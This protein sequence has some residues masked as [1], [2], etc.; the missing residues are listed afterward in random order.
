MTSY[1]EICWLFRINRSERYTAIL[2]NFGSTK[3][4]AGR[5]TKGDREFHAILIQHLY[6]WFRD[7]VQYRPADDLRAQSPM[8]RLDHA[9]G[10]VRVPDIPGRMDLIRDIPT[11]RRFGL[12]S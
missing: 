3:N 2:F 8:K 10:R 9:M 5:R 12:K 6:K 1:P 7:H 11:G 4:R